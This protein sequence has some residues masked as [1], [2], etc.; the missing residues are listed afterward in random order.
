MNALF[1][2]SNKFFSLLALLLCLLFLGTISCSK[3]KSPGQTY[4]VNSEQGD[5]NNDGLS[6]ENAWKTLEAASQVTYGPGDKLLLASGCTFNGKLDLSASG[7]KENPVIVTGYDANNGKTG[8]PVIDAKGYVAAIRLMNT[9]NIRISDLELTSDAGEP[10]DSKARLERYGVWIVRDTAGKSEH[11]SLKNLYIHD[12]FASESRSDSEAPDGQSNQGAGIWYRN[13][14]N[15]RSLNNLT[16]ENCRIEMTGRDGMRIRGNPEATDGLTVVNNKLK[17]IGGPG[18]V[19]NHQSNAVIRGNV[20][21]H[22]GYSG[23]PRQHGRG[24]GIWTN[25]LENGLIEN[26]IN[27]HARGMMDSYGIHIDIGCS[28]VVVQYNLSV[29]NIGGFVQI[30]GSNLNCAYRYNISVNDG[31]RRKGIDGPYHTALVK[32]DGYM[33]SKPEKGPFNSYIYNNTVYFNADKNDTTRFG[34]DDSADGVLMA[35]NIFYLLGG[36]GV[37]PANKSSFTAKNVVFTHNL[38]TSKNLMPS[39]FPQDSNPFYGNPEYANPG[40]FEPQDYIPGNVA[41]IK[42]KGMKIEKLPGDSIG[43]KIGLEVETDFL[44]NPVDGLPDLGA[45]EIDT[46]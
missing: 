6:K 16:I 45:I 31:W 23:D 19:V 28:N 1:N 10:V 13:T 43:L 21:D 5:D 42:D 34:L 18:I 15:Q 9:T 24:S 44:G 32:I 46:N 36:T 39:I 17:N 27:K 8:L 29:D 40:G 38:F 11:I 22:T 7:D 37:Y 26:N 12:I 30:L 2:K 35:N 20:T 25:T 4:Y 41:L 3:M 33:G 14:S